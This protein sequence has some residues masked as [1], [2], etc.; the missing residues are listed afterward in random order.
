MNKSNLKLY[1]LTF[2]F[3]LINNVDEILKEASIIKKSFS[4][5]VTYTLFLDADYG[6]YT[7]NALKKA[8]FNQI[9]IEAIESDVEMAPVG[10][11]K[12]IGSK[13]AIDEN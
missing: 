5:A 1:K 11:D 9:K 2:A 7:I 12:P 6:I 4:N 13:S 8:T 10:T 3:D